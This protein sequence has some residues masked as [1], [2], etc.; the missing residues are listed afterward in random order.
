MKHSHLKRNLVLAT[1]ATMTFS[2]AGAI[3]FA[4]GNYDGDPL[5]AN[6]DTNYWNHY[7]RIEPTNLRH[8]SKEFWANC[9]THNYVLV[10]PG[11]GE[12]IREGVS[13]D[14]TI[15]FDQLDSSDPRYI[16]PT[17]VDVKGYFNSLLEAFTHD[18]YSFIPDTMRPDG[19]T[20][21]TQASVTYDFTNFTN[22]NSIVYGGF[23]EQ[24][25][26]VIENIKESQTFYNITTYGSEV[27]AASRLVA[28]AFLDNQHGDSFS[29][30]FD[31]DTR[32][33][34]K[35]NFNGETLTYNVKFIT[36]V[37]VPLF[38]EIVPQVDMEYV[39]EDHTKTV[40][41]QLGENNAM[42][43]VITPNSYTFGLEY[44]IE[45]VSR[46]AYFTVTKDEDEKVEGHIFEFVTLKGKDMI[47]SCAD[48]YIDENYTSAVGNKANAILGLKGYISELYTTADGLL[49]GYE[50]KETRS[51]IDYNTLWFNLNNVSGFSNI[52]AIEKESYKENENPHSV[53]VNGSGSVFEPTYNTKLGVKTSRKYDLEL[54]TQYFYGYV[55]TKLT[56]FEC[57]I[58]MLFVQA[59]DNYNSYTNDIAS[60]SG[61]TSIISNPYLNKIE[62]DYATL[63]DIFI[64]NKDNMDSAAVA[65]YIGSPAV[66]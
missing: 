33:I 10:N 61:I 37:S 16:A 39:V 46:K 50:V 18:P 23:G 32:Y 19:V 11:I 63:I 36:G 59:G 26:M 65:D 22:V 8:G 24:W 7:A 38:G 66:I 47:S 15:Y 62:S 31:E 57:N 53:Y 44:G 49:R 58:P 56:E 14:T 21:H 9:S 48:F 45:T 60:K 29:K 17:G 43:F 64:T 2:I 52:K 6:S 30:T 12:D 34:S 5:L 1:I 27:L 51:L 20:K 35:L 3:A 54:R 41:I 28:S 25:H 55:D 4:A 40:R 13:F 42:K